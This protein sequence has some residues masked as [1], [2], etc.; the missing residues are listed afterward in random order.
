MKLKQFINLVKGFQR[1]GTAQ[2]EFLAGIP[3]SIVD[4][5][6]ENE[7]VNALEHKVDIL[8]DAVLEDKAEWFYYFVYEWKPGY[9]V[10]VD[11]KSYMLYT[12]EDIENFMA[13][14]FNWDA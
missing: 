13:L 12:L 10:T 9:H 8:V 11:E 6:I 7:Y 14:E 4:Y 2:D 5:T 3:D 1:L